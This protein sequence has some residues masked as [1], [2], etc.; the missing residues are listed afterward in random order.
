VALEISHVWTFK[1]ANGSLQLHDVTIQLSSVNGRISIG[2]SLY[3]HPRGASVDSQ[4][5]HRL[6][7]GIRRSPFL[8][9]HAGKCRGGTSITQRPLPSKS[10]PIHQSLLALSL[11]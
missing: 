5:V 4:Q 9:I 2:D 8:S 7:A 6:S 1:H 11:S 10:L 3:L